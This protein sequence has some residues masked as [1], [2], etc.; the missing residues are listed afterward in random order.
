MEFAKPL[1][2]TAKGHD[3]KEKAAGWVCHTVLES[4][5]AAQTCTAGGK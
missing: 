1:L 2:E 4:V 3:A 5:F